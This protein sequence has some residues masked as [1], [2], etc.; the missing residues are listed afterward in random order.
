MATRAPQSEELVGLD[1]DKL[2]EMLR[3]MIRGRRFELKAAE[4]YQL[5]E[6]GGF[7]HLYIGQEAIA[8]GAITPLRDDDYVITAYR[9][10]V[11][12]LVRGMDPK[13]IMAELF[14]RVSGCSKGK[15]GS[16]HL[17]DASINFLGGHAIVGG[18]L[19]L[20][21]GV[22][23]AIRYRDSDSVCVCFLGDAVTN[24]GAF[25]ESLNMAAL[26]DLPVVFVIENNR[27]GM[28]TA[29]NKAAA[30]HN[31]ADRACGYD[32]LEGVTI[33]G[34]DVLQVRRTI[35]GALERA[36]TEKKPSLIEATTYRY[37]G[38]SMS[39]PSH[40]AYRTKE[41]VQYF[42][43]NE[44]P[45]ARYIDVLK[46]HGLINDADVE[47]IENEVDITIDE[48]VEFAK[49]SPLPEPDALYTDIY[50]GDYTDSK[51]RDPWR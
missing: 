1:R 4:M 20:A 43:K 32:G 11:Q 8:T 14:G 33:D 19:P 12:A 48:S 29:V 37:V 17:F 30:I 7:L 21:V 50:L 23:Y 49:N 51:R 13:V 31:L 47:Q 5:G 34:M 44:D 35:V 39:D 16:M 26:W 45:I 41:E 9:D 28:G 36:R 6:I 27:F 22:G 15:G 18:H 2:I 3:S 10:H 46:R 25:N 24:I 38:H 40:G 42:K